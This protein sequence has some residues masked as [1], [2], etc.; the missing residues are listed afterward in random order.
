M[1]RCLCS[2][3]TELCLIDISMS[4]NFKQILLVC[5]FSNCINQIDSNI[6]SSVACQKADWKEHKRSVCVKPAIFHK[7]DK[8][9]KKLGGP[10]TPLGFVNKLENAAWEERRRNPAQI[11]KCDSCLRRFRGTP[12]DE[13]DYDLDENETDDVGDIFKR[14]ADC[15]F[16]ICEDCSKTENQGDC[17]MTPSDLSSL[18]SIVQESHSSIGH[19]AA[20]AAKLPISG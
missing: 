2:A 10:N 6:A 19:L 17:Q 4:H 13:D 8:M 16:T 12:V 15:D 11:T 5:S 7:V 20:V 1:R 18:R 14:C 3:P 9:M